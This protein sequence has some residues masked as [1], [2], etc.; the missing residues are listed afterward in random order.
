MEVFKALD[1]FCGGGGACLGL[2]WAGFEVI[3][4]DTQ[5]HPNYPGHFIQ[6]DA[7]RPPVDIFDFD[8]VWASPPCQRYSK[9]TMSRGDGAWQRHPDLVPQT[10]EL[11]ASHP[12]TCIENVPGAPLRK[13]LYLVGPQL[14]LQQIWR[15]RFFEVSFFCWQP[16]RVKMAR[17][18]YMCITKSMCSNSHFYRRKKEGKPGRLRPIEYKSAMGIPI[19]FPMTQ[20]E[21]GEAVPPLYAHYIAQAAFR[22][23]RRQ[24][25]KG[26]QHEPHTRDS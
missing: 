26:I 20:D 23:I 6:A 22:S 16:P 2:Q 15:K 8:F 10:R 21:V 12:Y 24:K 13:D 11:L 3:G 5:M 17:G 1:L 25:E 4:I 7:L 19:C 14:G 18:R 9:A